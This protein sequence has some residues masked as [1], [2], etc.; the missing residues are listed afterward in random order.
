MENRYENLDKKMK[1]SGFNLNY[2][3]KLTIKHVKVS[4]VKESS[5][6]KSAVWLKCKNAIVNPKSIN[7]KCFQYPFTLTQHQKEIKKSS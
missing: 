2:A 3:S 7:D 1:G 6:I 5:Y 4:E